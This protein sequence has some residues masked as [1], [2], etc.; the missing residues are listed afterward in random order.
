MFT[1][2]MLLRFLHKHTWL[3]CSQKM[4]DKLKTSMVQKQQQLSHDGLHNLHEL[5]LDLPNFIHSTQ[6]HPDLVCVHGS[7]LWWVWFLL[8]S[9]GHMLSYD[10]I[11]QLGDFYLSTLTFHHTS[12][13]K[14]QL[15]LL[16]FFYLKESTHYAIKCTH[17]RRLYTTILIMWQTIKQS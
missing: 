1:K 17:Q 14:N 15:S 5:V 12:F 6:I 3:F 13:E 11:F 7:T 10:T 16:H 4:P 9:P 8:Q 2:T